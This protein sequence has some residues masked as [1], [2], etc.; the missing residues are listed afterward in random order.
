MTGRPLGRLVALLTALAAMGAM[1]AMGG[2]AGAVPAA[3]A[4]AAGQADGAL[5][6]VW[7]TPQQVTARP[8]TVAIPAAVTEVT[9][10]GT[11]PAALAALT[12]VLRA[13]GIPA[14]VG[15]GVFENFLLSAVPALFKY[16]VRLYAADPVDYQAALAAASAAGL[17]AD[18]VTQSF[19]VAWDQTSSGEYLVIAVGGPADDALYYNVCGWTAPDGLGAGSTPF[20][21]AAGPGDSLPTMNSYENGAGQTAAET[22]ALSADLAYYAVHGSFPPGV[23]SPPPAAAAE[24]ACAGSPGS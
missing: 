8:G 24:Y 17:P 18:Q 21:Y 12:S 16:D 4:R 13:A 7:P 15:E 5:P 1:G 11:D 19:A 2:V 10:A 22:A 20:S 23:T 9:S 6:K 3:A 14:V